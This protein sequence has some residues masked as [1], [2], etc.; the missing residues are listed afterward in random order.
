M[1]N[2]NIVVGTHGRFGEELIKSTEMIV[3]K[4][5]MVHSL[6][7]LPEYSFEDFF[8]KA[9]ELLSTLEG[10]T[11]VFVDIFGGTPSN[12]LSVLT[13]KHGHHVVTGINMPALA[14]LFIKVSGG[15]DDVDE[16]VKGCIEAVETS[17][18][19]TNEYL[20]DE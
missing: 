19:Y 2:I 12:V 18:K 13:K 4:M 3:G 1:A 16:L 20:T 10:S 9:D 6:S 11:I 14:E 8:A 7:L 5:E 17:A 15:A